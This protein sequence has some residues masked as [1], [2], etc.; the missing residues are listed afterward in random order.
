MA[1]TPREH[2]LYPGTGRNGFFV[3]GEDDVINVK[4]S[5]TQTEGKVQG[6]G[7]RLSKVNLFTLLSLWMELFP[8]KESQR[9]DNASVQVTGLVV[10][11]EQRILGLHCTGA[12][13]HAGQVAVI[14]HGPRLKGCELYFSRKPCSVCLKMIINAGVNRI[15][16]WPAEAEISLLSDRSSAAGSRL[17]EAMLDAAATE[18]LKSSSR[19][20]IGVLLQ[21]LPNSML[22]F[23]EETSRNSDFLGRMAADDHTM[24]VHELFRKER[25][26]NWDSF[27]KRFVIEN[28]EVHREL[29]SKMNLENFCTEPYFSELRQHMRDLIRILACVAASVP[30][31]EH[32]YGF[33]ET[34][35][36]TSG[37]RTLS[38]DVVR[39]CIIQAAVLA[40]RTEDPKVGVGTVIWAEGKLPHCD[41]T[42]NMYLVGCGYNAYPVGSEYAEFPQ[43]DDKQEERQR[44]KY[45]YIIHAEQNALTFR[46]ADVK[47][48]ENTMLFVT[49]C[50][51]DECVPLIQGAGIKQIYTTDL[52]SGKDKHDISYINFNRLRGTRRFIWQK[53]GVIRSASEQTGP[54]LS[55]GCVKNRREEPADCQCNKRLK[56]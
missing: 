24:D 7:P 31:P 26:R 3:N 10:V 17:Q 49:K 35:Q 37:Y 45:R 48:E 20:H 25:W 34:E 14:R 56:K 54:A 21:P 30:V 4:E 11:H 55:N 19:P 33:Y 13:L 5:S 15:S 1:E 29:L 2:R 32:E 42:G 51:C 9:R 52:D 18:K 44:R 27:S 23:V 22:Q 40:Y 38:Q 6:H 16:Y 12:E 43:M 53:L 41:G 39:H 36:T 46:S 50:P 47:E 28:V 8:R